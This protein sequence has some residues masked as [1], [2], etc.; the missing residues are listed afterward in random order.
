MARIVSVDA[1]INDHMPYVEF[2]GRLYAL[3]DI[4]IRERLGRI[5]EFKER[6]ERAEAEQAEADAAA[7]EAENDTTVPVEQRQ[8]ALREAAQR[9]QRV[10]ADAFATALVDFPVYLAMDMTER[11]IAVMY[12][13]IAEAQQV[14][15]PVAVKE[16]EADPKMI[17]RATE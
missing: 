6:Q 2:R 10:H 3:R 11:E 15:F 1:A 5:L 13:A 14:V 17:G 7:K 12:D 16:A 4:T 8:E 9:V